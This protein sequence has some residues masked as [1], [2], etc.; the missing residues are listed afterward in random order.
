MSRITAASV[1]G[2]LRRGGLNPLGSGTPRTREGIRVSGGLFG[3]R[4]TAD[5]DNEGDARA[6]ALEAAQV[7]GAAGYEFSYERW[8][9][10]RVTGK[11]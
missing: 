4:V 8:N 6:L 2:A 11:R 9:A 3:V 1:S 10:L 7:L 5:L